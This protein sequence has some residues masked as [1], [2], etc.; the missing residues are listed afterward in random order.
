[1][2]VRLWVCHCVRLQRNLMAITGYAA[3]T[4]G[5]RRAALAA[6]FSEPPPACSGMCDLCAAAAAAAAGGGSCSAAQQQKQ[7]HGQQRQP[8]Q[9]ITAVALCAVVALKVGSV[10]AFLDGSRCFAFLPNNYK[11]LCLLSMH[12]ADSSWQSLAH[13]HSQ[14]CG[15]CCA[16]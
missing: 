3:A 5:C 4:S 15:A 11:R 12:C 14:S 1:M 2:A 13:H 16:M 7:Q 6:H 10:H 9:D 8:Q